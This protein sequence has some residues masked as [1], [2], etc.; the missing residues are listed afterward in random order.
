L[1]GKRPKRTLL[2]ALAALLGLLV[3]AG[4]SGAASRIGVGKMTV[5][6]N[7]V[8]AGSPGNDLTFTFTADSAALSGQTIVDVPAGWTAPQRTSPAGP[9]YV[10]VQATSCLGSTH[11]V[12]IA[13]RRL[14]IATACA[15]GR[16]FRLLYHRATAPRFSS[17]GYVFLTQT[18]PTARSGR[19][20]AFRPLGSRKQPVVRVRGAAATGLFMTNTSFATSG[21]PFSATVRATDAYGNNAADYVGTVTFSSTDPA[22][23]LP[24]PYAYGP[25]DLAQHTFSGLVLRTPGTQRITVTD[26]NGFSVTS[27][28]ITVSLASAS[29]R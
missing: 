9:G 23:T 27:G 14:T 13:K 16:T 19:R 3:V 1:V 8:S 18:R 26:S 5:T 24:T 17:D 15:R 25:A 12:A 29:P 21:T 11:L 7:R 4:S 10:E 6:P 28:P 2:P 22:A 20:I